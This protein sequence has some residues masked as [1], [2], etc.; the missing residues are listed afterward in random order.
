MPNGSR[1]AAIALIL[2]GCCAAL[3]AVRIPAQA[4]M[5]NYLHDIQL[6]AASGH[7]EDTFTPL[8]YP[9][10]AGP[11][12]RL[13][14]TAGIVVLQAALYVGLVLLA[15]RILDQLGLPAAW[16]AFGSLAVAFHP[17]LALS[18]PKV[19]DVDLSVFL[20]LLFVFLALRLQNS[21]PSL[22]S[23]LA[24]G[25]ALGA[26]TFCRPNYCLLAAAFCY[27]LLTDR[28]PVR[29]IA[30]SLV[31]AAAAAWLVFALFGMLSHGSV[32]FPRNGPYNLFAGNNP[33]SADALL[34]RLNGEPSILPAFTQEYPRPLPNLA[35]PNVFFEEQYEG[36]Y[37]RASAEFLQQHPLE[38]T[39]LVGIK[40][41]TLFRPDT[42]VHPLLSK[43]GAMKALLALPAAT[44]LL[45]LLMPGHP[46]LDRHDRLL[47]VVYACYVLP[48]LI[49][50]SDPRFRIPL[51]ALLLLHAVRIV[52]RRHLWKGREKRAQTVPTP[53]TEL[54]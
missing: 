44:V 31:S 33:H 38:E 4:P 19:W 5:P 12:Y 2:A 35:D 42:K 25:A 22:W 34:H 50:N 39:E 47:L 13:F 21:R 8:A 24:I 11:A 14:G 30:G 9:L 53:S 32:F 3:I 51:D 41:F 28:P 52:S 45:L 36:F 46:T 16:A 7:I 26:G 6:W 49:T 1:P 54:A 10:F 17:E 37:K 18:V 23:S 48:F 20:L 43:Q 29:T 27:A 40:L 15:I